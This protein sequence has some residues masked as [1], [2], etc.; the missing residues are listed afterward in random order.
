MSHPLDEFEYVAKDGIA[1]QS[2]FGLSRVPPAW[3]TAGLCHCRL[4]ELSAEV[5]ALRQ[6][7]DE[8]RALLREAKE[9]LTTWMYHGHGSKTSGYG[10]AT[11]CN[12]IDAALKEGK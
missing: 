1:Y 11:L 8:A 10:S 2:D 6:E 5:A 3:N 9:E 12:R 7:R 4:R